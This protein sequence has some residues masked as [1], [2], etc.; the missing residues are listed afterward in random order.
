MANTHRALVALGQGLG[1]MANRELDRE[2]ERVMA[3]RQENFM[4]LQHMLGEESRG[5]DRAFQATENAADRDAR[6]GEQISQV[7]QGNLDRAASLTQHRESV[8]VQREG[9]QLQRDQIDLQNRRYDESN[10]LEQ[11][12]RIDSRLQELNDYLTQATAE[13]KV[14]D[15]GALA[16][17]RQE[18]AQLQEQKRMMAQE[19]DITLARGG[20]KRYRKLT[21]EEVAALQPKDRPEPKVAAQAPEKPKG[22]STIKPVAGAKPVPPAPEKP[23]GM[24]TR[25]DRAARKVVFENAAPDNAHTADAAKRAKLNEAVAG[26]SRLELEVMLRKEGDRDIKGAIRARLAELSRST[27]RDLLPSNR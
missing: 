13:G 27:T 25:E 4:R 8:G 12:N 3:M 9:N 2:H 16:P 17:L 10:Y 5:K 6:L 26:K 19:R 14:M 18:A 15:E 22:G 20:D 21:K 7:E 23:P 24:Q 11:A 1:T